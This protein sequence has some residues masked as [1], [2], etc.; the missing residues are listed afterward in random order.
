[1]WYNYIKIYKCIHLQKCIHKLLPGHQ[2]YTLTID[3]DNKILH[4]YDHSFFAVIENPLLEFT[5]LV[6][7]HLYVNTAI[8]VK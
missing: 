8:N 5:K 4:L 3:D 1:M 7:N 2:M 6:K